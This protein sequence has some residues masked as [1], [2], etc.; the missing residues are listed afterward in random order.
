MTIYEN[1]DSARDS[2]NL[3]RRTIGESGTSGV[4]AS[5]ELILAFVEFDV[6]LEF[7]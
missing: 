5:G 2:A 3:R 1:R 6:A 7:R 4:P